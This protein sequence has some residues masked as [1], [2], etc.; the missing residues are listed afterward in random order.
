[1]FER[2]KPQTAIILKYVHSWMPQ[3]INLP[4]GFCFIL[5]TVKSYS[6]V[7]YVHNVIRWIPLVYSHEG[8]SFYILKS[9][10]K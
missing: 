4:K 10:G 7:K 5:I 6:S 3:E 8:F 1:M 9:N 2:L